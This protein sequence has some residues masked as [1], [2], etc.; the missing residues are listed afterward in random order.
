[1]IHQLDKIFKPKSIAVVGAST[2]ADS[3]GHSIFKNLIE[4]NFKGEVYPINPKASEI[5]G[6]KAY[7]NLA[8]VPEKIDLAVV[9][10]P[11]K[12]VPAVVE[13][14][15]QAGV[16]G[17]IIIS[18]G[19]KEAGEEGEKMVEQ[20]L[21]TCR[22]Y[23]MRLIGPNCLGTINPKL[24]MNATFA[25]RM[26]LPGNIAFI[27][28]SGAL[29]SSIL[30][31]ACE[32]NVGFSHFVS[33]GSMVDIGFAELIDYFGM[34][35]E[36]SSILI[37][38]E[39]LT[40]AR[41][42]MSAARAFARSKPIIILKA[43]KSSAGSK[44]A[45][46]HTGT[47]AGN[48]AA[49][50]AA[51]KRSGCLRVETISQLFN[52]AQALS[53]Q[54]RPRGNRLA[55]V[56]NAG[57]PGVLATDYLTTRGGELA[58]LSEKSLE[59]L[60]AAMPP[61][62][63]HGNPV[64]VL[65]D[66][67]AE[68]YRIALETCLSDDGVDGVLTILTTQTVTDPEGTAKALVEVSK[69]HRKPILA[70][71]MGE[72]D[73]WEAREILERGKI[74]N[75][76]Y[77]ESAVDVFVQMHQYSRNL[78]FLYETPPEAPHRFAPRR[79]AAWHVLRSALSEKRHYLLEHEAKELMRCYDLPVG[80]SKVATSAKE[81]G[82]IA[83][84]IGFPVV[85]KIVSPDALHKTDV[86]GVRLHISSEKEAAKAYDE[87]MASVKKHKPDARIVGVLIEQMVKKRFELLIGA[88]RDPIFGPLIVFGQGGVAVEV[89]KDTNFGLPPLNIALAKRI[90]QRTRIYKQLKGFRGIPG[91][92]LDDLAFQLVK[93]SYILTDYPE[94]REI[95]IN[96]YLVDETG[97]V[98]VDARVLLDDYQP[99]RKG[100]PYQHLVI[101]PYPEKYAKQIHLND[102]REVL[103]RPIRPED[104]PMEL[105][106][107]NTISDQSLYYRFFGYVPKVTHDFMIRMT[108]I[109]YDREMAMIAEINEGGKQ[110][111]I[112]VVRI[113]AD[114]W[115]ESA[116]FAILIADAWQNK[117]LGNQMMDYMLEIARD[118]GIL[119]IFASVL[120]TN[121]HMIRMFKE[122]GFELR[123]EEEGAYEVSL[124]LEHAMPFVAEL[125]FQPV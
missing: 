86:G 123:S 44:A 121:T 41:K 110:Q 49:F 94:V 34:D 92:D 19:F 62:W 99:R 114:A 85:M 84:E 57:G 112:G 31:W 83:T 53:M 91:V 2:K 55:I 87:I 5:L 111:M 77:P 98:V 3:V 21:A 39:S 76:R 20:I 51:F 88:I 115:S 90:I 15:G 97:G 120:R 64:D 43:G 82:K 29:C 122:R 89:I 101:S 105:E 68:G 100:H 74:P 113:I 17:L 71:W 93:F 73:V 1:M 14:C 37:Y 69:K 45:M 96:P 52:C 116:E 107:L 18:A 80:G 61:T 46:S 4:N 48:D 75:Y 78:E 63:S 109:D 117:G 30:D 47:L 65:G 70:A 23:G 72:R 6:K 26:A 108:H 124:D 54:P 32:Q 95:D 103:L 36:T 102:G 12:F 81:A 58:Q 11:S 28:Q 106:M 50:D 125:P 27:S 38:M 9:V 8:E 60:N 67:S 59:K 7:P 24:G 119:K 16:G 42:F 13:E 66:A 33:I 56:T 40:D 79:D 25:N 22:K 35:Q 10:V 118:K 104:E